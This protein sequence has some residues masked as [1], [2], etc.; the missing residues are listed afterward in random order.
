MLNPANQRV[1]GTLLVVHKSGQVWRSNRD[2]KAELVRALGF[3]QQLCRGGQGFGGN[4]ANVQ[5]RAS[6]PLFL[7]QHD[8]CTELGCSQRSHVSGRTATQY[9]QITVLGHSIPLFPMSEL[10]GL[11]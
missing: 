5:A 2:G 10:R 1:H 6:Y 4:T 8:T 9:G 3:H 11:G 7:D